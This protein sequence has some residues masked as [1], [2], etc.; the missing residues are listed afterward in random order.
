MYW[1]PFLGTTGTDMSWIGTFDQQIS[2][3]SK[4]GNQIQSATNCG[5]IV[6]III[7]VAS[8]VVVNR[9]LQSQVYS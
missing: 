9:D 3:Y 8:I 5:R 1:K 7:I 4:I 2:L 6:I